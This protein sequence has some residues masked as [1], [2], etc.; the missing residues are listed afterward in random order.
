MNS[1]FARAFR[2][3]VMANRLWYPNL[4]PAVRT[5][6]LSF[7]RTVLD[8]STFDPASVNESCECGV[9]VS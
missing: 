4:P 1:R 9:G 8:H 6:L 5:K 2:R 3:L 7:V